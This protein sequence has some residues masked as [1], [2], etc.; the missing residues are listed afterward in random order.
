MGQQREVYVC[1]RCG[2]VAEVLSAGSGKL[3]CCQEPMQI[4]T[5]NTA[6]ASQEKHVP[7]VA[8]AGSEVTVT[9]G[10]VPHPMG[11]DHYIQWVEVSQGDATT[12]RYLKPGAIPQATFEVAGGPI[13]ARAYCNLHGLWKA[14]VA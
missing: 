9:V 12:R 1:R 13:T 10:T 7:A 2:G 3:T 8:R 4:A 11:E 5:E 14:E 6:D